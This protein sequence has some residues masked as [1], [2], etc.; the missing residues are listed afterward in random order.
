MRLFARIPLIQA[1][2]PSKRPAADAALR[3]T[4]AGRDEPRLM[5]DLIAFGGVLALRPDGYDAGTPMGLPIDPVRLAYEAGRR[6]LAVQL[7]AMMGLTHDEL[8]F[9][10]EDDR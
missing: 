3:W 7:C 4:R 10:M 9:L 5:G 1:L 8:T 2:F 6:D